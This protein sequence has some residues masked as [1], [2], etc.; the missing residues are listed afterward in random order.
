MNVMH[1]VVHME[2]QDHMMKIIVSDVNV[3]IHAMTIHAH[4]ILDVQLM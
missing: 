2:S 3:K 4:K 1:Y